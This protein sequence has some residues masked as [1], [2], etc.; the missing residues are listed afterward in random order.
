[1]VW[2]VSRKTAAATE[3]GPYRRP[4]VV[5]RSAAPVALAVAVVAAITDPAG[6]VA[7]V[8]LAAA[9]ATFGLWQRWPALPTPV[10][11]AGVL[12]LVAVT[13][14]SGR[15]EPA[16]FLVAVATVIVAR[17]PGPP[18][19][20]AAMCLILAVSPA[21]IAALQPAGN[22]IAWGI[23]VIGI[24][25]SAVIGRGMYRQERLSDELQAARL[26]LAVQAQ[27]E[28]RRRI[29]RDVHDLVGHGLAAVLMQVTSARHVLR[30]DADAAEEA[31]AAAEAAGRRSMREL[32]G[33]MT[34][35][36]NP[37]ES[38]ET[39]PLPDFA[40]L[41]ALVDSVRH[42]DGL[43]V[44]YRATGDLAAVPPAAGVALYRIAQEALH[45]AARHA[46]RASTVVAVTVTAAAAELEV[47]SAGPLAGRADH[48]RP[49]Y[50]L[51][52]MRERAATVGGQLQAGPTSQGWRV[53]ARVPV[54]SA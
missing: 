51:I 7:L 15:L 22:R 8:M 38:A 14:L 29:A 34:L 6:W 20:I 47:S 16:M 36:R 12:A 21:A 19:R 27:A 32:R 33:T 44:E 24:A 4:D 43:I 23:W 46:P 39:L 9:V 13:Q 26:Q 45:N 52:G 48:S 18:W 11:A 37:G 28:E 1:M 42:R 41:G 49:H 17:S 2:G 54:T 31:L 53:H 30:R 5:R 10:L 40:Q 25:F 50:G 3:P 35:L